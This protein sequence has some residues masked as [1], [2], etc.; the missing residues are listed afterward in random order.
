MPFIISFL[1]GESN[2]PYITSKLIN[3]NG[4]SYI[5][6]ERTCKGKSLFFIPNDYT[7]IDLETTG[8][9]SFYDSIIEVSAIR[10][11]DNEMVDRFSS[12]IY[13]DVDE[14]SFSFITELTGITKDM[15]DA[16]PPIDQVF[17]QFLSFVGSDIV[18]GHNVNFDVNFIYDNA[19][20]I[21]GRPFIN[22][23]VD[24]MR[25]SKRLHPEIRHHRLIDISERYQINTAGNHRAERDCEITKACFDCISAEIIEKYGNVD[26]FIEIAKPR[27]NNVRSK[28]VSA[29]TTVFD[30]SHPLYQ[31]VCVIT[32]TLSKFSRK[33]AMQA[34]SDVGGINGDSVTKKTNYLII[35]ATDYSHVKGGKS[36]KHKKAED[37]QLKGHDIEIISEDVFYELLSQEI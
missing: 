29:N 15:I 35:G 17:H 32:G 13:C 30:E 12:L 1:T 36:S 25:L 2:T 11:R 4:S 6:Y 34:I 10:V 14:D 19:C 23:F 33:E 18:V 21:I 16:A 7:V 5:S 20:A 22:D 31:K 26:N 3:E 27:K 28:D 37:L 8:L 9:S 24:T